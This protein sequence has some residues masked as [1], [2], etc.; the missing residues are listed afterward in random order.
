MELVGVARNWEAVERIS[1]KGSIQRRVMMLMIFD[2]RWEEGNVACSE[3][4]L[5][6]PTTWDSQLTFRR[7]VEGQFKLL[8]PLP[9]LI[10]IHNSRSSHLESSFFLTR[11]LLCDDEI[12][13][14]SLHP[15]SKPSDNLKSALPM[16]VGHTCNDKRQNLG[17]NSGI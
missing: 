2:S 6:S 17:A 7:D 15:R 8:D 12:I 16:I 14:S 11:I 1:F 5:R 9:E 4:Q 3:Y 10:N 13:N